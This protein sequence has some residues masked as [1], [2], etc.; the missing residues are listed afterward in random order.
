M[1]LRSAYS[2]ISTEKILVPILH[3]SNFFPDVNR[4]VRLYRFNLTA[5]LLLALAVLGCERPVP[6]VQESEQPA[7]ITNNIST[8]EDVPA[9]AARLTPSP[10]IEI[11]PTPT[12]REGY[13]GTP[14][15]DPTRTT[16]TDISP[17]L[18]VHNVAFGETLFYIANLYDSTVEELL[19][20][21]ELENGDLLAAG[22][23][24]MV[25]S[26]EIVVSPSLKL[27]PDSE[28][29]Y[30]P[31][32][33]DFDVASRVLSYG[34][35]LSTYSEEVEGEELSGAEIVQLVADRFSV[36]PRLL[37]A[38]LE[39]RSGWLTERSV[40]ENDYPLG[41]AKEDYEGLYQQLSWA[42]NTINLGYYGRSEGGLSYFEIG[43]DYRIF[44]ADDINDGTAGL[45][46]L[47]AS[48]PSVSYEKWNHDIDSAGF[49]ETYRLL[50]RNPFSFTY[51]PLLPENLEQTA[52]E[53]PFTNDDVWYFTGGPHGGWASGSAWAAL[54]F[55]PSDGKSNCGTSRAWVLAVADGII[56]RSSNGAVVLDLDGD[57]FSGTG[58]AV[59]YMHLA[60]E[61]RV[62]EGKIVRAGDRLGHPSCEGG[63][64][65]AAH[66]HIARTYNGRW[67]SADG[68]IPFKLGGWVSQG[69]GHEYDGFLVRG[70]EI[71]EA[72]QCEEE[73]NKISG[74]NRR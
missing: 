49:Y 21:N 30:G 65:N 6:V 33:Q 23:E 12:L 64:S 71:K 59:T 62:P 3:L 46:L 16:S 42:A 10:P 1:R 19:A 57:G 2:T 60:A 74:K 26:G 48:F 50:F 43:D 20:I 28:L 18:R 58:W 41:Y 72:C 47:F 51:D 61:D 14:T 8:V 35:L 66:L 9:A 13:P 68:D 45:Q 54:D 15:P 69:L 34:G 73:G 27:I 52:F 67:V 17:F 11:I 29:V 70:D 40:I 4:K 32:L 44:F 53:M 24:L 31:D 39:Y 56:S 37:L 36:N 63:Y 7:I 38:L 5:F 25:P 22:Q 55:T